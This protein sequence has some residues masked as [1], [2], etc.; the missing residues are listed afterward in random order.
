MTEGPQLLGDGK[1]LRLV[2]LTNGWEY[3]ERVKALWAVVVVALTESRK[4]LLIEQFRPPV[5]APVI[6][7]PAGLVGDTPGSETAE[8][9][10]RRELLEETGFSADKFALLAKGPVSPGLSNELILL[11]GTTGAR[12][13]AKGG[14][15]DDEQITVH[16]IPLDEVDAFLAARESAGAMID[17]KIY[18]GLHFSSFLLRNA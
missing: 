4:I 9:A 5:N 2:K 13:T 15:V 16:E 7:L 11:M 3:A 17:P 1:H 12:R 6:E 18:I 14:G 10:A 8:D